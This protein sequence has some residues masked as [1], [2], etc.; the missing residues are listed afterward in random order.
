MD[1]VDRG[2]R[3][4][5]MS[6]IRSKDTTPELALRAELWRRGS[7][8]RKHYGPGSIDIAF[9]GARV[10]VF[11]DGCFWHGCP[12]HYKQPASNT[13]FWRRKIARNARRDLEVTA[14]LRGEGWRVLRFWEH[15]IAENAR[16]VAIK[17]Q[18]AVAKRR[19][20]G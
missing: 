7:R 8:Y 12:I 10:A 5:I 19:P 15:E 1:T 18:I 4:R 20:D 17:V 13:R 16:L 3:S 2:T 9:P 6:R 14:R 11:V